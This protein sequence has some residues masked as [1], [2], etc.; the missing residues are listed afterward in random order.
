VE[1]GSQI[2]DNPVGE[3]IAMYDFVQEVEDSV[4]LGASD[5]FDFNPFGEFVDVHPKQAI[6]SHTAY[7]IYHRVALYHPELLLQIKWA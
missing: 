5:R 1:V 6:A 2:S 7:I 4:C 3:A